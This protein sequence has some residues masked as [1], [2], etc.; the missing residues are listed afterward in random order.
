MSADAAGQPGPEASGPGA[1][2]RAL[3]RDPARLLLRLSQ[4]GG[5]VRYRGGDEP[6]YLV[7]RPEFVRHV[8]VDNCANYTKDTEITNIFRLVV[9]DGLFTSEAARWR[10]QRRYLGP[11]FRRRALAATDSQVTG[12]VLRRLEGWETPVSAGTPLDIAEEMAVITLMV[13]VMVLFGA[14]IA[15]GAEAVVRLVA[16][17]L[18]APKQV[19]ERVAATAALDEMV[20]EILRQRREGGG[21]RDDLLAL[22][23]A[24]DPGGGRRLSDVE[25]RDQVITFI[26]AG[27]ETTAN[28][29]TWTW[30]LLADHPDTD[31]AIRREIGDALAGRIAN[32]A[33]CAR[34]PLARAALMESLRLYPPAW[35]IGRRALA[36]DRIGDRV[37]PAGSVVALSPFT[38]HR[39]PEF[40]PDPE[41][42]DPG[43]FLGEKGVARPRFAYIPFG[44][45]PRHCIGQDF[46]VLEGLLILATV[47]QRYA[48]APAVSVAVDPDHRFVLRPP[49]GARMAASPLGR[50]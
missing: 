27:Y 50:T 7:N 35:V 3:A 40:W 48:F 44:G 33:D 1:E 28:A 41:R 8:L 45:G 39:N 19:G 31:L 46:A 25:V 24:R 42:F 29:L 36:E 32:Y 17:S 18:A 6:A 22:L 23:L 37:I 34:L 49:A 13:T 21:E 5:V 12:C 9:N 30:L 38:M 16:D 47:A 2:D 10:E 43:R 14:D 4:R 11:A 15:A 26:L 20:V